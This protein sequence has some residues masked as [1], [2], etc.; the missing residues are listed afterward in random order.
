MLGLK[1]SVP[2]GSLGAD[3]NGRLKGYLS[4]PLLD[5]VFDVA[6]VNEVLFDLFEV[7]FLP[8]HGDPYSNVGENTSRQY[9]IPSTST[10][11]SLSFQIYFKNLKASRMEFQRTRFQPLY[12]YQYVRSYYE[13]IFPSAEAQH[14]TDKDSLDLIPSWSQILRFSLIRAPIL[15]TRRKEMTFKLKVLIIF[16]W[17]PS[18][19]SLSQ[20]PDS[21]RSLHFL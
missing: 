1:V 4:L 6:V 20:R 5:T 14:I 13:S 21:S 11:P 19:L 10:F 17:L 3:G 8:V 2:T 15:N 9:Q 12:R 16:F 18:L 7:N